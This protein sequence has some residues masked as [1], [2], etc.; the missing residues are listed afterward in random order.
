[1]ARIPL[2]C[3]GMNGYRPYVKTSGLAIVTATVKPSK[4]CHF[5]AE[6]PTEEVIR[7]STSQQR[8]LSLWLPK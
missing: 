5:S 3:E 7:Q 6:A 8:T 1:M 2:R 4:H